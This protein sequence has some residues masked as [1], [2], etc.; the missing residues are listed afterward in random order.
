MFGFPEAPG[1]CPSDPGHLSTGEGVSV[2]AEVRLWRL[3]HCIEVQWNRLFFTYGPMRSDSLVCD[4]NRL[5][6]DT[7]GERARSLLTQGHSEA[8]A[9]RASSEAVS[10]SSARR[11]V[12]GASDVMAARALY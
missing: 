3:L 6:R 2:Y 4:M 8:E 10:L 11:G 7:Y 12:N 9:P 5:D 1:L